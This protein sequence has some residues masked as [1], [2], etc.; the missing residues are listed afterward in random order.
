[1]TV[2]KL[3][4]WVVVVV[5]GIGIYEYIQRL[6]FTPLILNHIRIYGPITHSRLRVVTEN[7]VGRYRVGF[8]T[9][10]LEQRGLIQATF[11]ADGDTVYS[12]QRPIEYQ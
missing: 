1:M 8:I 3:I 12:A 9:A 6:R 11:D 10:D 2:L 7:I 5:I 4:V